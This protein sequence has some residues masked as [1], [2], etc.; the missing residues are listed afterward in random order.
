M[1]RKHQKVPFAI[2]DEKGGTM[3]FMSTLALIADCFRSLEKN[4][5]MFRLGYNKYQIENKSFDLKE[6]R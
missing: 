2:V 5:T 6:K 4:F 3:M 1:A